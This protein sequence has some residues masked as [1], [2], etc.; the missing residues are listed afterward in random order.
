MAL[1]ALP[2]IVVRGD[3]T[4][5]NAERTILEVL[6]FRAVFSAGSGTRSV[7][8]LVAL[9]ASRRLGLVKPGKYIFH[10]LKVTRKRFL[11]RHLP[12]CRTAVLKTS[13]P[14]LE[15]FARQA[16]LRSDTPT[17]F[18]RALLVTR[19]TIFTCKNRRL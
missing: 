9:F 5:R 19:Q 17:A 14:Q 15:V 12:R 16:L 6:T 11:K 13:V 7:A 18:G 3:L 10:Q 8:F 1:F 2:T 4:L